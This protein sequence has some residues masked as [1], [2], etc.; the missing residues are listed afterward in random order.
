[1][2]WEH[3]PDRYSNSEDKKHTTC[4][5]LCT[6]VQNCLVLTYLEKLFVKSL[7]SLIHTICQHLYTS[8]NQNPPSDVCN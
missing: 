5:T 1:M 8:H 6:S 3:H 4:Q 2:Y 7:E